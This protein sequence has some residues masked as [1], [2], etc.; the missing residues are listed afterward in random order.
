MEGQVPVELWAQRSSWTIGPPHAFLHQS[1]RAPIP[2]Q[3]CGEH[4]WMSWAGELGRPL[5]PP[6][7]PC[8]SR[9]GS[10]LSPD[11]P[12][13][14][15]LVWQVAAM[16]LHPGPMPTT[17]HGIY[18][19]EAAG[20]AAAVLLQGV[21]STGMGGW[22]GAAGREQG[23]QHG[24]CSEAMTMSTFGAWAGPSPGAQDQGRGQA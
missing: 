12:R 22:R 10:T 15:A 4:S 17:L 16:S 20:K 14:P 19:E 21:V 23:T 9:L 13:R 8:R 1:H 3:R 7:V 5:G 24:T 2:T 11:W 18:P 6:V